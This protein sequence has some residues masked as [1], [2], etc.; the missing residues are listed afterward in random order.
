MT[1]S[2][3]TP[4]LTPEQIALRAGQQVPFLR[5][6]DAASVFSERALRLRQL[7]AGHSM[8]DFLLFAADLA[9]AQQAALATLPQVL[10]PT[11]DDIQSAAEACEPPLLATQWPRSAAW[12]SGLA[13]LLDKL[14][15]QSLPPQTQEV[16][17][18]L[19][20]K[21]AE[22]LD[23]QADR[24]LA[25]SSVGVD[26]ASAPF[27]AAALQMYWVALVS[28]TQAAYGDAAVPPFGRTLDTTT[29]P[30]CGS[31]PVAS[32]TRIGG[33]ASGYRYLQCSLCATQWH[34]VRIKCA[35]C[36]STKGIQYFSLRTDDPSNGTL[37]QGDAVQV[38]TCDECGHYLKIVHMTKNPQV[39]PVADDLASLALDLLV[40][41]T[42][43]QPHGV[44]L[45]LFFADSLDAADVAEHPPSGPPRT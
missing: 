10:P 2:Q 42:G 29:C 39:E 9:Q 11:L 22:A 30:C 18:H 28:A 15:T 19:R 40:A 25:G 3:A 17:A 27:I 12:R 44:N 8:R 16:V 36:E 20:A 23:H 7:A 26:V 14:S 43:K 41:D 45:M 4:L 34:M 21:S 6:P 24:I 33:D 32:V 37:A 38:E 35:H 5:L 31:H 13:T 1:V